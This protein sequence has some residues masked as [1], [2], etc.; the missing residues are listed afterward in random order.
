M[1]RALDNYFGWFNKF[2]RGIPFEN[3]VDFL[4]L[5]DFVN[6]SYEI[7]D[8]TSF[9]TATQRYGILTEETSSIPNTKEEDRKYIYGIN[10][11]ISLRNVRLG[12]SSI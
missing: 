8:L 11:V 9:Q 2:S 1:R 4:K 10:N 12:K 7:Y 6:E 5:N 3:Y